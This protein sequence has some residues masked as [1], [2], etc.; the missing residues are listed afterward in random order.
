MCVDNYARSTS[1]PVSVPA[2]VFVLNRAHFAVKLRHFER[3]F[4]FGLQLPLV[5][6]ARWYMSM[7][8]L[9]FVTSGVFY[10][11]MIDYG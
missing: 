1:C 10:V 4:S 2:Q 6:I 7:F 9:F 8:Y 5:V 11:T 3:C